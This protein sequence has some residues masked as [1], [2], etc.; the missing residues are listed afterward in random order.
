MYK[1]L[2]LIPIYLVA[3]RAT[4]TCDKSKNKAY[5]NPY[6]SLFVL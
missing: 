2:F 5:L 4:I 3:L 6:L 1:F